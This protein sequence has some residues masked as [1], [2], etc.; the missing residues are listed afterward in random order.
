[1]IGAKIIFQSTWKS[2]PTLGWDDPLPADAQRQVEKWWSGTS[3][4]NVPFPRVFAHLGETEDVT[5]HVFC[6]ASKSAYCTAVYAEHGG[7][8]RLV[9]AKG[10]LAPLNPHLT[11]PRL[12]LMAALI[13]ARLMNFIQQTLKLDS[14]MV[15]FW[16]DSTD[17]LHWL[18]NVKPRKVFVE[19]RVLSILALTRP[20]QWR[21]V[22]GIDNP[23]DLGTRGTSLSELGGSKM[24][25]NCPSFILGD[26]DPN[27]STGSPEPLSAS[28]TK[29]TIES[30][31]DLL[32]CPAT[33]VLLGRALTKKSGGRHSVTVECQG[34]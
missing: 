10:R 4:E 9:M 28:A 3:K 22:R 19:N 17:V 33:L 29:E 25:W 14:P 1:M 11:I 5:F 12:E 18:W 15:V 13:G 31:E 6:D 26:F 24:W 30:A 20:E 27:G 34:A 7:E 16:T 32:H 23:A 21:H 8:S 2:L